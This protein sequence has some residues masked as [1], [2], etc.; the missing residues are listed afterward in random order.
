M[1]VEENDN[2]EKYIYLKNKTLI[3]NSQIDVAE[4]Y[5]Y[6]ELI[7]YNYISNF[8]EHSKFS[9]DE[10]NFSL[11]SF[12]SQ[13]D[14]NEENNDLGNELKGYINKTQN[15]IKGILNELKVDTNNKET[16]NIKFDNMPQL[17]FYLLPN[18]QIRD[19]QFYQ[20]LI[21][22]N[23]IN[24]LFNYIRPLIEN[25]NNKKQI[26]SKLLEYEDKLRKEEL[27]GKDIYKKN[28]D[29]DNKINI[30]NVISSDIFDEGIKF[31]NKSK[32]EFEKLFIFNLNKDIY[33]LNKIY[34]NI[35]HKIISLKR[36]KI[37]INKYDKNINLNNND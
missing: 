13:D 26:K 27:L 7:N 11:T 37:F 18:E 15:L 21:D 24:L 22:R 16:F 10:D 14:F 2:I 6:D 30:S 33:Y 35:F 8:G 3:I 23:K 20:D 28:E 1:L 17:I 29:N 36:L 34:E 25:K 32:N 5:L 9:D 31:L 4:N 19:I 12:N